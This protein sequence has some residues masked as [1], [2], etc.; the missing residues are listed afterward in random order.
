MSKSSAAAGN[1]T[2]DVQS[3][4][5]DGIRTV[6]IVD[7]RMRTYDQVANLQSAPESSASAESTE[8]DLNDD[9]PSAERPKDY[10][11]TAAG[12][13]VRDFRARGWL[14]DV[15]NSDFDTKGLERVRQCDLVVLDFKLGDTF[16]G[17][18]KILHTLA[19]SDRLHLVILYTRDEEEHA[20]RTMA[21]M[22]A[23][24]PQAVESVEDEIEALRE[25]S[26]DEKKAPSAQAVADYLCGNSTKL[27]E[28]A[29]QGA[30]PEHK[31]KVF[32]E[33]LGWLHVH[34][35]AVSEHKRHNAIR[36]K[37][38]ISPVDHLEVSTGQLKWLRCDNVFVVVVRKRIAQDERNGDGALEPVGGT[39]LVD[40]LEAALNEWNPGFFRRMLR[41]IRHSVAREGLMA[42]AKI[43]KGPIGE[44]ALIVYAQGGGRVDQAERR[45][46]VYSR[47]FESMIDRLLEDDNVRELADIMADGDDRFKHAMRASKMAPSKG[48]R[49][50]ILVRLNWFLSFDEQISPHLRT[51]TIF[52]LPGKDHEVGICVTPECDL[53]PGRRDAAQPVLW[54]SATLVRE[55][56]EGW[57]KEIK[58]ALER[59]TDGHHLFAIIQSKD[60][61]EEEVLIK[62]RPG[63]PT[64]IPKATALFVLEEGRIREGQFQAMMT[65][66][67]DDGRPTIDPEAK[68]FRVLGQLRQQL[69]TRLLHETG[70][71]LSRVG[72]DFENLPGG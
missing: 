50:K 6:L 14:H 48:D 16:E 71:E 30:P 2:I 5:L 49:E 67:G 15:L 18:L 61:R 25:L 27:R 51:G 65:R 33:R 58:R 29:P 13:L 42:D 32:Q 9:M 44:A 69:A 37:L 22:L 24:P 28:R 70:Q 54:R 34:G 11:D 43:L 60:G 53:V 31:Q 4:F 52:S 47:M 56:D 17:S 41:F 62:L 36:E 35:H 72:V 20:W 63:K 59:A 12:A 57:Q 8:G 38:K 55:S 21:A 64:D 46:F 1:K 19:T 26:K 40:R 66:V 10:E 45:R 68:H 23:K 3:A 7:D 39:V